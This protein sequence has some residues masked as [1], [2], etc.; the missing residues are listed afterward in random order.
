MGRKYDIAE[1]IALANQRPTITIDDKHEYEINTGKSVA[2]MT[3]ALVDEMDDKTA[4]EQESIIDDIIKMA[5]GNDA[6]EYIKSLNLTVNAYMLITKVIVAAFADE[7]LKEDKVK[8][9]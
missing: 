5:L 6:I 8:K 3:Q 7:D 2:I 4:Q 1:K 9:R